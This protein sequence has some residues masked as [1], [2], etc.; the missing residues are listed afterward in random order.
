VRPRRPWWVELSIG[1]LG[2]AGIVLAGGGGLCWIGEK[3]MGPVIESEQRLV[4]KTDHQQILAA[5]EELRAS[6]PGVTGTIGRPRDSDP[7]A[8]NVP[9]ALRALDYE[10]ILLEKDRVVIFFGSGFGHWGFEAAPDEPRKGQW[11]LIPG[12]LFWREGGGNFPDDPAQALPFRKSTMLFTTAAISGVAACAVLVFH[13]RRSSVRI[14]E[15]KV[16]QP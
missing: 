4:Y 14:V 11:Q 7:A 12:L 13:R 2:A 16:T 5:C 1:L 15:A 3:L 10:F 9:A 6:K 8:A